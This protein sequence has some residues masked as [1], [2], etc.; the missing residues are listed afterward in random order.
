[1]KQVEENLAKKIT[2]I[3]WGK[4]FAVVSDENDNQDTVILRSLSIRENNYL[5]FIYDTEFQ[6]ALS[7]GILTQ[8][9]L[10]TLF[11]SQG[12]WGDEEEARVRKLKND[13]ILMGNQLKNAEFNTVRK[14]NVE[15]KI[16]QAKKELDELNAQEVSLF[17]LSAENR[18]EEVRRRLMVYMFTENKHEEPY[19]SS[20]ESFMESRDTVL[21]GN[22]INAYFQNNLCTEQVLRRIARS[23]EWR[24]RWIASKHGEQLFG[25]PISEWSEMQNM[26]VYWSEFYDSIYESLERPPQYV[27]EDDT[28]CDAWVANQN[29]VNGAASAKKKTKVGQ[30]LDHSEQ[31]IMVPQDDKEAIEKVQDLNPDKVRDRLKQEFDQIKHSGRRIKEWD[32]GSRKKNTPVKV[33][34]KGRGPR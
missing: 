11:R 4:S 24:F 18:A 26:L 30:K 10:R 15:K 28:A 12:V 27:I 31:F 7:V 32:L 19:W 21:L 13:L 14:R 34:K 1:M 23:G 17:Y 5:N 20:Q 16:K 3:L 29:K 25:R 6:N 2:Q 8:D 33:V 22:L 9:Q